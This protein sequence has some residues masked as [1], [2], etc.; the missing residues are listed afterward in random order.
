MGHE[1]DSLD[2]FVSAH[3]AYKDLV[4]FPGRNVFGLAR[5]AGN[6]EKLAA[7]QNDFEIMKRKMDD[8]AKKATKLESKIKPLAHGHQMR[9]GKLWS[10]IEAIFKQMDTAATRLE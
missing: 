4:Y 8:E 3:D 10:Q 9:A 7:L 2:D 1:N 6:S 5:V